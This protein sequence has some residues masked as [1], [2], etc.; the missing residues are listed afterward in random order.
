M[1]MTTKSGAFYR[2]TSTFLYPDIQIPC[3]HFKLRDKQGPGLRGRPDHRRFR[4]ALTKVQEIF[5]FACA[6]SAR[7]EPDLQLTS[8]VPAFAS[9]QETAHKNI[10]ISHSKYRSCRKKSEMFLD[11]VQYFEI[12]L[13]SRWPSISISTHD[14]SFA[15]R[16]FYRCTRQKSGTA[17]PLSPRNTERI[18]PISERI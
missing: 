8:I 14:I 6:D 2:R 15:G 12:I 7:F 10:F 1:R 3:L 5:Q 17:S 9:E 16:A 11:P 4:L 18:L 13:E